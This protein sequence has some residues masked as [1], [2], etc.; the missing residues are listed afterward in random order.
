M[1]LHIKLSMETHLKNSAVRLFLPLDNGDFETVELKDDSSQTVEY[2]AELDYSS[3]PD[4]LK[5]CQI[6]GIVGGMDQ[7]IIITALTINDR[8]VDAGSF[9]NLLDFAVKGNRFAHDHV[10]SNCH[11]ICFNG[12]LLL[13]IGGNLDRI[14]WCPYYYSA[15]KDDF[16]F[17]NSLLDDYGSDI[18]TYNRDPRE[19]IKK[20]RN[21][22]HH[23]YEI[24]RAYDVA[25]FGCSVTYGEGLSVRDTWGHLLSE[26]SLNLAVPGLGVDGI[27]LNLKNALAK[28]QFGKI[29]ILL[30]NFDRKLI[31]LY[32][33]GLDAVCRIP[34]N[35][36][37]LDWH[38]SRI[39]HWA[40]DMMG[41]QHDRSALEQ[42]KATYQKRC[43]DMVLAQDGQAYGKRVL[44]R[45]LTLLAHSGKDF[46]LSS[47]DEEAYAHLRDR[48]DG[49][50]ILPFFRSIDK[51]F[52]KMHP[53]PQ[54]HAQWAEQIRPLI[55]S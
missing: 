54:S 30:P 7:K 49:A 55:R 39:K 11:E 37:S 4:S 22:P 33:P 46:Y 40:W 25:C 23:D 44:D 17:Q 16:V 20:Y 3:L 32:L 45:M 53:G 1:K 21:V 9:F 41:I 6:D 51:A 5:I 24:D 18:R 13:A 48:V 47:W 12:E 43:L 28:F 19:S 52:D 29:V 31:R 36:Q 10:I 34:V 2:R 42:W 38:H 26:N 27:F 15:K 8:P 35:P 14:F 50:V